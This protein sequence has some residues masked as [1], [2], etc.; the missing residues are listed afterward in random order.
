MPFLRAFEKLALGKY[1]PRV[2]E[3][4]VGIDIGLA[5]TEYK[6]W[7]VKNWYK[8]NTI[9]YRMIQNSAFKRFKPVQINYHT[10]ISY[11]NDESTH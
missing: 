6:N 1:H 9:D 7:F 11:S 4:R 2:K 8:G 10:V 5:N 3:L